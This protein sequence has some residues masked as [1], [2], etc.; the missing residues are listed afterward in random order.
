MTALFLVLLNKFAAFLFIFPTN[1]K[2]STKGVGFQFETIINKKAQLHEFFFVSV[3]LHFESL[4]KL[5]K[6]KK[7]LV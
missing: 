4:L 2:T 5:F 6:L 3:L 7:G 1:R